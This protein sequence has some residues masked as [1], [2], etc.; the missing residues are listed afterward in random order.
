V[1]AEAYGKTRKIE[2][3]LHTLAEALA[4]V[5]RTGERFSEAELYRLNGEL[6]LQ[7]LSVASCQG[8]VTTPH[9]P[10]ANPR[11]EAETYFHKAIDIARQ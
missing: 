6:T 10:A 8:A 1:L 9:S 2:E 7:K 3:G 4:A 5:D 11:V